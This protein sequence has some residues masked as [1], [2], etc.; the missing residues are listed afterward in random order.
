MTALASYRDAL[1]EFIFAELS[2]K[3]LDN[4]NNDLTFLDNRLEKARLKM[5]I[6]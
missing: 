4:L 2:Y 5:I 3:Q 1:D 6:G